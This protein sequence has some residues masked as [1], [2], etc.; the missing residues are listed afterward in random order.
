LEHL[1]DRRP[2]LA[3]LLQ[4]P[5][6]QLGDH[7]HHLLRRRVGLVAELE[8]HELL[9]LALLDP[10]DGHAGQVDLVPLPGDVHRRLRRDELHQDDAEAVHIALVG[11]LV[12][13]VILRIHVPWGALGSGGDVR[14]VE[15]EEAG[16]AKVG[17][18]D[19]E[20]GVEED[21][22]GLDVAVHDGWLDGVEV[23]ERG[24]RLDGD[25]EAERPR[26]RAL[27]RAV[28]VQVVGH[29]AVGHELV[30]QEQLPALARRAPVEHHQVRVPQPRQ[31]RRLVHE[32]LHPPVAVVVQ[33]LH[34][35]H[36]PVSKYPYID[37]R[38]RS[39]HHR[40]LCSR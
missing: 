8:V 25:V 4:A 13:L 9:E 22:G 34:R 38:C 36:A 31:D 7:G 6:S 15:G 33:P 35:H 28:A 24:G 12:A 26:E 3:V 21:V 20:V 17:D 19:V 32:L 27:L 2:H 16:E 11:K 10:V 39:R 29:R 18:L 1:L 30:H 5:E 40:A 14:D 23:R 37:T